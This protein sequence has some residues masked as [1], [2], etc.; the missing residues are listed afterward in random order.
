V[1]NDQLLEQWRELESRHATVRETL[2]RAL[3]RKHQLSL[4]EYEVLRRLASS[5]EGRLRM[6]EVSEDIHLTQSALSRLVQRLE[7]E[8]FAKRGVCEH[9]RRGVYACI[10][11]S[12]RAAQERAEPTHI[13]ALGETL[14]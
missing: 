3:Q 14:G 13:A 5:P 8:G 12:G 9:D 10:T 7:E 1:K 6:Q 11:D 2:E 4:T